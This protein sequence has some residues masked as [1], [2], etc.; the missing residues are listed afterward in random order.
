MN[1]TDELKLT[2]EIIELVYNLDETDIQGAFELAKQ[3]LKQAY[4]WNK[5]GIMSD[6][7][8]IESKELG[9]TDFKTLC[10][11]NVQI[12]KMAHHL[13]KDIWKKSE[14]L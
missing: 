8:S 12:L 11:Q 3:A 10:H 6:K 14:I 2:D 4:L 13:A 9:K 5:I 7:F 1:I